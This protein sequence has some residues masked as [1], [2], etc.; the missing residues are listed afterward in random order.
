MIKLLLLRVVSNF[1]CDE[2]ALRCFVLSFVCC[3][4][5]QLHW[6]GRLPSNRDTQ[7]EREKLREGWEYMNRACIIFSH[8][9]CD[10]RFGVHAPRAMAFHKGRDQEHIL[11]FPSLQDAA[12][13]AVSF[14]TG[15]MS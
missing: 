2:S 10:E 13:A 8:K 15:Y 11:Q 14:N 7:I 9:L 4:L 5:A 6:L 3:L 12:R 1:G